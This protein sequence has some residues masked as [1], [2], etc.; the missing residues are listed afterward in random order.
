MAIKQGAIDQGSTVHVYIYIAFIIS[1]LVLVACPSFESKIFPHNA[2][3]SSWL[4]I[5]FGVLTSFPCASL[6]D[7]DEFM[8]VLHFENDDFL[9]LTNVFKTSLRF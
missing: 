5:K 9:S 2:F 4:V 3:F 1:N 8:S 7:F 6:H